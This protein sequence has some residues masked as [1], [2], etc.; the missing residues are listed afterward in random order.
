MENKM[1]KQLLIIAGLLLL[2][3]IIV[4]V[5]I[6]YIDKRCGEIYERVADQGYDVFDESP[7]TIDIGEVKMD[8]VVEG[9]T[10]RDTVVS[11]EYLLSDETYS[12]AD[13]SKEILESLHCPIIRVDTAYNRIAFDFRYKDEYMRL[14]V[15]ENNPG[16]IIEDNPWDSI[17]K[18]NALALYAM[19]ETINHFNAYFPFK[20]QYFEE[21][22]VIRIF[23]VRQIPLYKGI[24]NKPKYVEAVI[25]NMIRIHEYFHDYM[26]NYMEEVRERENR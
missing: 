8:T 17:E 19:W 24:P 20:I 7:D 22:D 13:M 11:V 21:D 14:I 12:K 26:C 16:I 2:N 23:S 9:S 15:K 3:S 10:V 4:Y 18:N 25:R 5:G 1:K 6:L